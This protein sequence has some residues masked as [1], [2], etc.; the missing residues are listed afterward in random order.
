M[1]IVLVGSG[2]EF[3]DWEA[4]PPHRARWKRRRER[5][6]GFRRWRIRSFLTRDTH[7]RIRLDSQERRPTGVCSARVIARRNRKNRRGRH[8]PLAL[9]RPRVRNLSAWAGVQT[10]VGNKLWAGAN[11]HL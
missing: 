3:L 4:R 2:D 9:S 6:G 5:S 10:I 1:R 11:V 8:A 7:G